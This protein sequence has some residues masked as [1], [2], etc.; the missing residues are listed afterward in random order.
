MSF[1]IHFFLIKENY[2][3]IKANEIKGTIIVIENNEEY[4]KLSIR[5]NYYKKIAY[6]YDFFPL[7]PGDEVIIK[8][9]SLDVSG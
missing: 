1:S 9:T 4:N 2:N 5:N 3:F 8:G 7:K 6:D